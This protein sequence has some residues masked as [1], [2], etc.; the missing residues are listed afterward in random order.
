MADKNIY[1]VIVADDEDELREAVCTMIPWEALGFHL[2]GSASNGLDA[3]ELVE[4][5]EP[6]LLLTDIRMPFI[7]GIELARQVREIRPAMHIAFLS[8]YDDFEYAKQAIKLNVTEYI[9]KPVNVE[10]LTAI[11]KRIKSNLDEEI[12]QKRNVSLLR[13]NYIKS[14]PILREQ[15][16]NELISYPVPEET[17]A[18][19]LQ[20]YDIPLAGAKKWVAAAIDIEPEEIRGS[21][22]LP[23]HK[24]KDLIPIS[25]M[26]IVEEKLKNYC[27]CALATS[28]R[29]AAA[30]IAVIAAIDGENSQ[31]GLIDVL[32]DICKETK[33]ILEVPITVG[34]GHGCQALSEISSSYKAAV[35]ALGYKAI[36][37]GGST[38]YINDVEPVS[39]GKLLFDGKDEAELIAAIKFGPREKI[40]AAARANADHM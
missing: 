23:L 18:D 38:I 39:G 1:T 30:E 3:L 7:S 2:V 34:I 13:E 28:A 40:E 15:F 11:L 16:I 36:V 6:D 17:V 10:E 29:T 31:T 8:G 4:R 37:G 21:A 5:L 25:V 22:M 19:R 27:R 35:D 12:E 9:L 26:Q 20:E 24:E 32:G 14:L 33:K